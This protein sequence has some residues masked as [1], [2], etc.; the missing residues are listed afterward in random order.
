MRVARVTNSNT[1][2][3]I[4][5]IQTI[6]STIDRPTLSFANY[7][8]TM[9]KSCGGKKDLPPN[10]FKSGHDRKAHPPDK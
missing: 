2:P 4:S 1:R 8:A 10:T 5:H 7:Y 6:E 9:V 3:A